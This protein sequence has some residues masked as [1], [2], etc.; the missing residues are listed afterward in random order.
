[1]IKERYYESIKLGE[2]NS[3]VGVRVV[4]EGILEEMVF[5]LKWVRYADGT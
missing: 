4:K 5:K 2:F 3:L 1:M